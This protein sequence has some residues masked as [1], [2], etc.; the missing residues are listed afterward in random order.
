[1]KSKNAVRETWKFMRSWSTER[2]NMGI[3]YSTHFFK[4][5]HFNT[6]IFMS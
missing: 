1:M 3:G 2:D 6:N 4:Q 5:V